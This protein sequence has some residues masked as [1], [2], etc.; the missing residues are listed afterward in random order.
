MSRS[1]GHSSHGAHTTLY[2]LSEPLSNE[3]AY[4][5]VAIP[6]NTTG[7]RNELLIPTPFQSNNWPQSTAENPSK[8][9]WAS[10]RWPGQH[11]VRLGCWHSGYIK[12]SESQSNDYMVA[13]ASV[14]RV[15]RYGDKGTEEG[16]HL[17]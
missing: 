5:T 6:E 1:W 13:A 12:C 14:I 2:A 11:L 9:S 15:D 4:Q 8:E 7:S 3:A 17:S 10:D 16:H